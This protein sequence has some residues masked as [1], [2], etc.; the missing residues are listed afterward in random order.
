MRCGQEGF[1]KTRRPTRQ[2]ARIIG[3]LG[4]VPPIPGI[5]SVGNFPRASGAEMPNFNKKVISPDRFYQVYRRPRRK[6]S[7][8]ERHFPNRGERRFSL[9]RGLPKISYAIVFDP[10]KYVI[11]YAGKAVTHPRI[12]LAREEDN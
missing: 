5:S 4:A 6:R 12:A 8:G 1:G 2:I 7:I 10:R 3:G 11:P 9:V